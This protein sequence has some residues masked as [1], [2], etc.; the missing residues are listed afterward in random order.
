MSHLKGAYMSTAIAV[1]DLPNNKDT[2]S[3]LTVEFL[4]LSSHALIPRSDVSL[5]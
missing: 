5:T 4:L 1:G 2:V 3:I